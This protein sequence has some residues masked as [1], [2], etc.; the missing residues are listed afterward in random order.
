MQQKIL[1]IKLTFNIKFYKNKVWIAVLLVGII[2]FIVKDPSL[3]ASTMLSSSKKLLNFAC[4]VTPCN[5]CSI[6]LYLK[7]FGRHGIK[8]LS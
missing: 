5:I 3:I 1:H 4:H 6:A 8:W 7:N 2:M